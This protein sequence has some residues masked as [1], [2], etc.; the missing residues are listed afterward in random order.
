MFSWD[1]DPD[2]NITPLMDVMLVLMAVLM[3]VAPTMT[4]EENIKLPIGTKSA[5]AENQKQLAIRIDK[6]KNIYID[7]SI[8][9]FANLNKELQVKSVE[10]NKSSSVSIRADESLP[11]K[12]VMLLL[13]YVKSSGFQNVALITE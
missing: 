11:Y 9:S 8:Y 3:I 2:L 1:D 13:R 7:K 5:K 10:Y 12:D 6:D 4:Y